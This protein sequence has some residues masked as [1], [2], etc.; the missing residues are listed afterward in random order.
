MK[1]YVF[2]ASLC[3]LIVMGY[4]LTGNSK[5][6]DEALEKENL[7]PPISIG[8]S[9]PSARSAQSDRKERSI[10]RDFNPNNQ[11][12]PPAAMEEIES[13]KFRRRS[14]VDGAGFSEDG[15]KAIIENRPVSISDTPEP[16]RALHLK[17]L[18][19]LK[20]DGYKKV[21][22]EDMG[23]I[24]DIERNLVGKKGDPIK[25]VNFGPSNL[26]ESL[27]SK[28]AYLG[29]AFDSSAHNV[30]SGSKADKLRRVFG[31]V[32]GS[33]TIVV[34][35]EMLTKNYN[36]TPIKEFL[37]SS[38]DGN[39]AVYEE[40]RSPAKRSYTMLNWSNNDRVYTIYQFGLPASKEEL[41]EI[42]N[43]LNYLNKR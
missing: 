21:S 26:P 37:N 3:G 30:E 35:E 5:S 42:G 19:D 34:E 28:Y 6:N 27:S 24:V 20:R 12:L 23:D 14:L 17:E 2:G 41:L 8:Q 10:E 38:I 40:R 31:N 9:L 1:R 15:A 25:D 29:Y 32:E 22:E 43:N 7:V 33:S 4:F 39:P 13:G 11:D 16:L 36:S 18:E